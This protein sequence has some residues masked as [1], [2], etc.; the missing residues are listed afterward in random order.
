MSVT[1]HQVIAVRAG[2][3]G[4]GGLS[5]GA[6]AVG[7][8]AKPRLRTSRRKGRYIE[9]RKSHRLW[10]G[11]VAKVVTTERARVTAPRTLVMIL[12]LEEPG[13]LRSG[14]ARL[15][16]VATVHGPTVNR[17]L[18]VQTPVAKADSRGS[19]SPQM[20]VQSQGADTAAPPELALVLMALRVHRVSSVSRIEIDP[21]FG[22]LAIQN[23]D[24]IHVRRTASRQGA[25]SQGDGSEYE[26]DQPD[27]QRIHCAQ[28]IDLSL[29]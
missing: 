3:S 13:E 4:A 22:F 26:H 16:Q 6:L 17:T 7:R 11:P 25:G 15:F 8:P 9:L 28:S 5:G 14:L 21:S 10:G 29:Q 12:R 24:R 19:A 2:R 1:P 27:H 23:H 20:S 18:T